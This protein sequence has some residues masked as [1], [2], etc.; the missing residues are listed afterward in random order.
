MH[1]V[2]VLGGY[3]F[4]GS[5]ICRHLARMD[6]VRVIIG[7]R[8]RSKALALAVEL[9]LPET[10]AQYVD[11]HSPDLAEQLRAWQINTVI[12]TVGP[13]QGQAYGVAL[14]AIAAQANYIDLADGREFVAGIAQL[15]TAAKAG[16]VLVTSGASSLP[17]LSSAVVD[18]YLS[19]F[20]V[21]ERIRSGIG[22]GAKTPGLATMQGVFGYCGKPFNRFEAGRWV[23]RYGWLD[24]RAYRFN[25]PVGLRLMG[26]CDVPDLV[27]FPER[28]KDVRTVTFQAGYASLF[29]HFC[30]W[31][32]SWLV[33]I[34][35][36]GNLSSWAQPL[37]TLSHHVED[38]ISDKGAMYVE[39]TGQ[40]HTGQDL[41]I[42]WNLLASQNHGPNIP[43]AAA[44][45]IVRKLANQTA[46]P[47][48][49]MPCMGLVTREEYLAELVDYDI[50][51]VRP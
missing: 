44:V 33:R 47:T 30:L 13:F 14:A 6:N 12:H 27:L 36:I 8:Q 23:K 31:I 1:T 28:Y 29:S 17:A 41:H 4:F 34:G 48:G 5:R 9:G 39:L 2:L 7:G 18:H 22:S 26:N 46:L 16:N 19:R 32:V 15:D 51:E 43:C 42:R 40:D 50:V 35:L 21:L 49:A 45:A 11:A 24:L 10:Q 3:G 20:S 38:W 37:N 25:Q